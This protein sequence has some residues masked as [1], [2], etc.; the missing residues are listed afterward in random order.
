[1]LGLRQEFCRR[2]N[3]P[4]GLVYVVHCNAD[5]QIQPGLQLQ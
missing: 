4:L 2:H 1:V 3:N 5:T